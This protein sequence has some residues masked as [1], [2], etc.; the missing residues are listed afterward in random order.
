MN[1]T[2]GSKS[3]FLE[4]RQNSTRKTLG[5]TE[6]GVSQT[7]RFVGISLAN[8]LNRQTHRQRAVI[9][10]S[11]NT[12]H[13]LMHMQCIVFN[14]SSDT[15]HSPSL[16]RA[17]NL[18]GKLRLH[19][20]TLVVAHLGPWIREES[21]YFSDRAI[22]RGFEEFGSVDLCDAQ[23]G[24]ALFACKQHGM[25]HTRII[26]LKRQKIHI[27]AFGGRGNNVFALTGAD[28]HNQRIGIAP[29]FRN[30]RLVEH[31]I[32]SHIKR[33]LARVDFQQ[34]RICIGIPCTLQARVE[35]G[36]TTHEGQHLA[37]IQGRTPT[38]ISPLFILRF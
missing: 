29:R 8:M 11:F 2:T 24:K 7:G 15:P 10:E 1:H 14:I 21:P 5:F 9:M 23:I 36:G 3:F 33:P 16:Q 4:I 12:I 6:I 38:S 35:P 32:V 31:Q 27:G 37:P 25:R 34:I 30:I 17:M 26:N 20:T 28:F 22:R 13:H 19:D 18:T